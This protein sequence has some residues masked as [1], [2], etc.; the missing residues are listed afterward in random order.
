MTIVNSG[1]EG[2]RRFIQTMNTIKIRVY[3]NIF[4]N[5]YA[6]FSSHITCIRIMFCFDIG[7]H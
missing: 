4:F 6:P 1:L 3:K 2:L 7:M 5:V